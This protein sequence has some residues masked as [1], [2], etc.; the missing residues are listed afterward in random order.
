MPEVGTLMYI[1]VLE[2]HQLDEK[3][4]KNTQ[5]LTVKYYEVTVT[6]PWGTHRSQHDLAP[7]YVRMLISS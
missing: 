1:I 7:R 2:H 3:I 6:C 5:I 4:T